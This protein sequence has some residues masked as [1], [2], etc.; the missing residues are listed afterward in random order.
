MKAA[1]DKTPDVILL[2]IGL[3]GMNGYEVC[4]TLRDNPAFNNTV[5]IAQTG[6]GQEKDRQ[7]AREAG[8]NHHL[9]KPVSLDDLSAILAK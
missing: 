2:D 9:T 7:L 3:P 5:L 6:W 1:N 8:F 4:R